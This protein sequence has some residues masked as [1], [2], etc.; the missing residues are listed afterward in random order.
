[1]KYRSTSCMKNLK[2]YFSIILILLICLSQSVL[3][4]V[5]QYIH[6]DSTTTPSAPL[7]AIQKIFY[8]Q[9]KNR[10]LIATGGLATDLASNQGIYILDIN[11]NK[12]TSYS[13][14]NTPQLPTNRFDCISGGD[15]YIIAGTFD[16]GI[17]VINEIT[18]EIKIFDRYTTP[19]LLKNYYTANTAPI[20]DIQYEDG[21]IYFSYNEFTEKGVVGGVI[22]LNNNSVMHYCYLF[23][24]YPGEP[25]VS[26][27]QSSLIL[28]GDN[29]FFIDRWITKFNKITGQ[30]LANRHD[31]ADTTDWGPDKRSA[32]YD[33]VTDRLYVGD[34]AGARF[35]N[36]YGLRIYD[37]SLN[38]WGNWDNTPS[39][40]VRMLENNVYALQIDL[41][42]R[43]LYMSHKRV[44]GFYDVSAWIGNLQV[45]D[46]DNLTVEKNFVSINEH[47]YDNLLPTPIKILRPWKHAWYRWENLIY[48]INVSANGTI[49]LGQWSTHHQGPGDGG[50]L[51]II[52]PV[53]ISLGI[54]LQT[55]SSYEFL[56][57]Q[58]APATNSIY[59]YN[60]G[61]ANRTATLEILN[62][63]P[64]LAISLQSQ[65]ISI[66]PGAPHTVPVLIDANS[67]PV[68]VY[69]DLLLKITVD[70]GETLYSSLKVTIV[71]SG[72]PPLPDLS[73]R[74][75]DIQMADYAGGSATLNAV[76]HNQGTS[77]ASDVPVEIYDLFGNSLGSAVLA[78]VPVKGAVTASIITT[79]LT[80]GEHLVRVVIDPGNQIPEIDKS[81]NEASTIIQVGA[82][83]PIAGN[84]LVTGS[85]P[86]NVYTGTL[87]T[88]SGRGVYDIYVDGTRYTD[89]AV[90]GGS[91][92]ITIRNSD[93]EEWVYGGIYTTVDGYFKKRLQAP[94]TPGDYEIFMTVTDNTFSGRR[95]LQFSATEMDPSTPP[96]PPP[97]ISGSG[98]WQ[99]TDG[100]W[101]W[102]W[103]ENPVNEPTPQSDVRVYS[104][105]IHFTN[106]NPAPN[107][108]IT[109]FAQILYWASST[110][111]VANNIPVNFY[112]TYPG[113]DKLKIGNTVISSMSVGAPDFG[114]RYVYTTWK[115]Y[116]GGIYIVEVEI[117]PSYQEEN[118]KNNAATRAII[119]GQIEGGVVAG[120]VMDSRGGVSQVTMKLLDASGSPISQASTDETGLYL[121]SVSPGSY[122]VRIE[123]PFGYTPDAETKTAVVSAGVTEV[124][125]HLTGQSTLVA[126][127]G[128]NLTITSEEQCQTVIEGSGEYASE[129]RWLKGETVL[130]GWTSLGIYN[131][132]DLDLCHLPLGI[133]QHTLTLEVRDG[134]WIARDDMILTIGNSAPHAAP[135]GGGK[136]E[137][138]SPITVGGQVSDFDGDLLTYTWSKGAE[139]PFCSGTVNTIAGGEPVDLPPFD[140]PELGLGEHT[141]TLTVWDSD[142]EPVSADIH[143]EVVSTAVPTLAPKAT[144]GI[145]W[146]PN[147]KMVDII[148]EANAEGV[149]DVTLSAAVTSNEP[150]DGLGDGQT[151]PDWTGPVIDQQ[152]GVIHLQLRAERSGRGTGRTYTVSITATDCYENSSSADVKI[153]VPHD[154]RTR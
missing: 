18:G 99:Y 69:D 145:L 96:P 75:Q 143:I 133:G 83:E 106:T 53:G 149:C 97:N 24:R 127:A 91:V 134:N 80:E 154:M 9:V 108:E 104:E 6:Y 36:K 86:A 141:I 119:V 54:T 87:F 120:Q 82:G 129:F 115:N 31:D 40:L 51:G 131:E 113:T 118:L 74:S 13:T 19:A 71:A 72:A 45:V 152:N 61:S 1:M 55:A 5:E 109:V 39:S 144:P 123:T 88:I 85:L 21:K 124:N 12:F 57:E 59:L 29:I 16:K 128:E 30:V 122:Q 70:N 100:T 79:A 49:F 136:Y 130:L 34:T 111:L 142:N 93:G 77:A 64:E 132:A 8:D 126:D 46:L 90:K 7:K 137:I 150:P 44:S 73:I 11:S 117:D 107:E 84:I 41:Q 2:N 147:H 116:Q 110:D 27:R 52:T 14:Y 121:F 33:P 48:S 20:C 3:A 148:I 47:S 63:H 92:Q 25:Y 146:P 89:Y 22:D 66:A 78:E 98:G 105:N 68:G 112:V 139:D 65:E 103:T 17:V 58:N 38:F 138:G 35:T 114:S 43:K 125:F 32:V 28:H 94:S 42:K 76:I 4:Q 26:R 135:S 102:T 153:I 62:P 10:V 56:V 23:Q 50:G 60:P 15:N 67:S 151:S 95:E 140:L 37:S 101:T 81:N